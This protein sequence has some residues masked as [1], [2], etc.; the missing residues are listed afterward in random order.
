M[1]NAIKQRR[2][3]AIAPFPRRRA[4]PRI[5]ETVHSTPV[6]LPDQVHRNLSHRSLHTLDGY[7][8]DADA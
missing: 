5:P 7:P 3:C 2:A 4:P 8:N 6:Q 1:G